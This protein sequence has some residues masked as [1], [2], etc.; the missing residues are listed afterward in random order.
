M[1]RV[2]CPDWNALFHLPFLLQEQSLHFHLVDK[3]VSHASFHALYPRSQLC[4]LVAQIQVWIRLCSPAPQSSPSDHLVC[5]HL[6]SPDLCCP[7]RRSFLNMNVNPYIQ[8][9]LMPPITS[10]NLLHVWPLEISFISWHSIFMSEF[11]GFFPRCLGSVRGFTE[12][13]NKPRAERRKTTCMEPW[14][15]KVAEESVWRVQERRPGSELW[16]WRCS[17]DTHARTFTPPLPFSHTRPF[18]VSLSACGSQ[19]HTL[20]TLGP[21]LGA[22]LAHPADHLLCWSN[23]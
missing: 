8:N 4:F 21:S 6:P 1:S 18:N 5:S 3:P 17:W 23:S 16:R 10:H 22:H 9:S 12:W 7:Q 13:T 11:L 15:V 20:A 14:Q 2:L 19:L